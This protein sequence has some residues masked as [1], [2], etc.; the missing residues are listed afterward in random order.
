MLLPATLPGQDFSKVLEEM[1]KNYSTINRLH[2]VMYVKVYDHVTSSRPVYAETADIKR[3]NDHYL[4][5]YGSSDMFMNDRYIIMV[6]RAS[7]EIFVNPRNLKGEKALNDPVQLNLDSLSKYYEQVKF[8]GRTG[9]F[10]QYTLTQKSGMLSK[11]NLF[12]DVQTKLIG[13]IEY[14]Y[15]EGQFVLIEFKIFNPDPHFS[16]DTFSDRNFV[17]ASGKKMVPSDQFKGFRVIGQEE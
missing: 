16:A 15:T 9:N 6:D 10:D 11:T 14:H 8:V 3:D 2:C 7:R 13:R 4:Y 12:I 17:L 1:R 5:R